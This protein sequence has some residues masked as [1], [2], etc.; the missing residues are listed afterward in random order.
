MQMQMPLN[1]SVK[2]SLSLFLPHVSIYFRPESLWQTELDA[3]GVIRRIDMVM[4]WREGSPYFQ[5]FVHFWIWYDTQHVFEFQQRVANARGNNRLVIHGLGIVIENTSSERF[6]ASS[7]EPQAFHT[8]E[9]DQAF[10]EFWNNDVLETYLKP[11]M[12][13]EIAEKYAARVAEQEQEQQQMDE[14]MAEAIHQDKIGLWTR[15]KTNCSFLG[16]TIINENVNAPDKLY[17]PLKLRQDK[18]NDPLE[19]LGHTGG[20]EYFRN[21]RQDIII[22]QTRKIFTELSAKCSAKCSAKRSTRIRTD[23]DDYDL[24]YLNHLN[25]EKED[26]GWAN[27]EFEEQEPHYWDYL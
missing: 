26:S 11:R 13:Q 3:L 16:D 20:Q 22:K 19:P 24:D 9:T 23:S 12:E 14:M 6:Y 2:Q 15:A 5:V 4:C 18:T 25:S 8:Q 21:E 17:D 27:P 7:L 1:P 10:E